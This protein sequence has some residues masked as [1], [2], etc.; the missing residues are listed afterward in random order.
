LLVIEKF[1][2]ANTRDVTLGVEAALEAL[3]P[4]LTGIKIDTN[5]FR[6]AN[7]IE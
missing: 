7:Y 2:G 4:G 1:P 6:P 3:G 5:I